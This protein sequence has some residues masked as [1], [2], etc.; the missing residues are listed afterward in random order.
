[1]KIR[2]GW[3]LAAAAVLGS[4][5]DAACTANPCCGGDESNNEPAAPEPAVQ[6]DDAVTGAPLC[7]TSGIVRCSGDD[8]GTCTV[9]CTDNAPPWCDNTNGGTFTMTAT[10]NAPDHAWAS[11]SFPIGIGACG[12]TY[13][14]AADGG[15]SATVRLSPM[16][17]KPSSHGDGLGDSWND[18]APPGTINSTEATR[19]CAAAYESVCSPVPCRDAEGDAGLFEADAGIETNVAVCT[20]AAATMTDIACTCWAYAGP[21]A[22]HVRSTT[23]GCQCPTTNDPT[24]Q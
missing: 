14:Y 18:C 16:C 5:A 17:A 7:N 3:I 1:L 11:V 15:V 22:G 23:A 21:A 9:S 24:W 12:E 19:A 10:V 4:Q 13:V 2:A 6:V 20:S 8:N